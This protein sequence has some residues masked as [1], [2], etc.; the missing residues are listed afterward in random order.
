[1]TVDESTK[2]EM[3]AKHYDQSFELQKESVTKR[4][5]LFLYVL[6]LVLLL[7]I[8]MLNP[9]LIS[10]WANTFIRDRVIANQV[11]E[12]E[13]LDVSFI[14]L[15]LWFGLLSLVHT[16]FQTVLH[17]QR[18]YNYIYDIEKELSTYYESKAFTREGK[19]YRKFKLKFSSLT[20]FIYWNVFPAFLLF[21]IFSWQLFLIRTN[22]MPLSYKIIESII[23]III[24]VS[25]YFYLL[26]LYK[27]K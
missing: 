11:S 8:Y 19:H 4:D 3:L 22:A 20:K 7:L 1:M 9:T 5:R 27:K 16:Y 24:L 25:T 26:A 2:L 12:A 17:V 23:S 21:I 18:Q 10:D 13:L 6:I 14:G 15:I